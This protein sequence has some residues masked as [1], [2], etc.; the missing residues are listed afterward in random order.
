MSELKA[1]LQDIEKLRD[2]LYNLINDRNADL[3][4]PE[5]IKA[6]HELNLAINKY[7]ELINR[8]INK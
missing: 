1:L 6:S 8:K 5:V 3:Q 4:D 2:R 7:N